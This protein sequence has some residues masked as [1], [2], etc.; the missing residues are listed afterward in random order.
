MRKS[1]DEKMKPTTMLVGYTGFVGSNL[2]AVHEFDYLINSKNIETTYGVNPDLLVYA[3]VRA[4]K[5]LANT[6]PEKDM[7]KIREALENIRR[8]APKQLVLISTVDVYKS[9]V[10]VDE[11]SAMDKENLHAYG[12]NRLWLEEQ[13]LKEFPEA[14]IMRL[15]GLF[16]KKLKKNFIY[17][18]IQVIPSM[19]KEE[20]YLEL[21]ERKTRIKDNYQKQ[22]NGFYKCVVSEEEKETLKRDFE[23]V[24]FTA[25]NFTDSRG[26]F[27]F[28]LLTH[29]WE[30]INKAMELDIH[31]MNI[32]TEPVSVAEIYY[33][34]R[35]ETFEN[36]VASVPPLYN[37][38]TKYSKEFGGQDGYIYSKE[39]VLKEIREFVKENGGRV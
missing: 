20:K 3:G 27:Q 36:L 39:Q 5:F 38:R 2:A 25:L 34:L 32:A 16:G 24:G 14:Y 17:D 12:A 33:M 28:Y 1:R 15:P 23:E 29:L 30:H 19:L 18:Y 35:G 11:D 4:E 31:K 37:Y 22:E 10:G 6:A 13:V 26:V 21:A 9:P 8:I 7:E